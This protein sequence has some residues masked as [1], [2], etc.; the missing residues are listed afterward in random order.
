M[1]LKI[2]MAEKKQRQKQKSTPEMI[3][4]GYEISRRVYE[5]TLPA[6]KA[7]QLF[8][9]HLNLASNQGRTANG[10]WQ[11]YLYLLT[12]RLIQN[13]ISEEGW[14]YNLEKIAALGPAPLTTALYTLNDHIEYVKRKNPT[15][16][17]P[18]RVHDHFLAKLSVMDE[19]ISEKIDLDLQVRK[20]LLATED[21]RKRAITQMPTV[22][23]KMTVT[24]T[25]YRRN[26]YVIAQVLFRSK[27]EC[28]GCH[29]PAPFFRPNG[30]AYLEVHHI[31]RLADGG[32]DTEE[33]AQALCPN[34][35]RERHFGVAY[36]NENSERE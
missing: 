9:S 30:S 27:G 6:N 18:E 7:N 28:E 35:H 34:C 19:G 12:R 25:V 1:K 17:V 31:Q 22:P 14:R 5:G 3:E 16:R 15:Y 32:L 24:T 20:A 8:M 26:P 13:T 36:S 10:Y 21:E 23:E 29:K 4:V 33:N 2:E 11:C